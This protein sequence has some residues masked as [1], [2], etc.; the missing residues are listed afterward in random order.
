M[1]AA[2][3]LASRRALKHSFAPMG[4]QNDQ[5]LLGCRSERRVGSDSVPQGTKPCRMGIT[6]IIW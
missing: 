2:S 6:S 4:A 1:T 3:S 5:K